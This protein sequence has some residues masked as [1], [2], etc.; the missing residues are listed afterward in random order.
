MIGVKLVKDIDEGDVFIYNE[1]KQD[2]DITFNSLIDTSG[3]VIATADDAGMSYDGLIMVA[4]GETLYMNPKDKVF[5]LGRYSDLV[6]RYR[7]VDDDLNFEYEFKE[8]KNK[9]REVFEKA[10]ILEK[11]IINIFSSDEYYVRNFT[12]NQLIK[13]RYLFARIL[14]ECVCLFGDDNQEVFNA[15]LQNQIYEEMRDI[16]YILNNDENDDI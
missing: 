2:S 15:F 8:P 6:D 16:P 10:E 14:K 5:V 3:S 12:G 11:R 13:M 7:P 4:T 1:D 9:E